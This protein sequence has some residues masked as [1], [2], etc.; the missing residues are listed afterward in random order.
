MKK[1]LQTAVMA[2]QDDF[3]NITADRVV[4]AARDPESPLHGEFEW[5]DSKAA[6]QHRLNQAR[7]L[8]RQVVYDVRVKHVHI[9]TVG[10]VRDPSKA[11]NEQ[12]YRHVSMIK[13]GDDIA[14]DA[15]D[16]EMKNIESR[17]KRARDLATIFD[18]QDEIEDR[19]ADMI[20]LR[21]RMRA[22]MAKDA[23]PAA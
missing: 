2:L 8:I 17:L 22:V 19:L 1:E 16:A 7:T 14:R 9:E 15:L 21:Q 6:A 20:E 13:A 5:D 23:Q 3:G 4:E 11:S 12:G 18:L 10:Y